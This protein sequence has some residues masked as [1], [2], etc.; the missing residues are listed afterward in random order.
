MTAGI[1]ITASHNPKTIMGLRYMAPDGGQLLTEA[2]LSSY[3]DTV[4]DPLNIQT[5]AFEVLK[6]KN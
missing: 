4:K 3:I 5:E 2:S 6:S 1:M